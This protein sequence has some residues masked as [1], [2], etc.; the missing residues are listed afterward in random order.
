M[1]VGTMCA[2]DAHAWPFHVAF[3]PGGAW[4]E[5]FGDASST[6]VGAPFEV[7]ASDCFE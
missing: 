5:I 1:D 6:E 3:G 2:L 7:T 4:I